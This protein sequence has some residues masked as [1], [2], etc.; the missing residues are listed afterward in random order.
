MISNLPALKIVFKVDL[1]VAQYQSP[2]Q[3][4]LLLPERRALI[5]SVS[6]YI[7]NHVRVL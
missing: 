2:Y 7:V 5:G 6:T 1:A 3:Q 4:L